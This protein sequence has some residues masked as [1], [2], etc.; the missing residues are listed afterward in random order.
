MD[1]EEEQRD[2]AEESSPKEKRKPRK[3]S[4]TPS[5]NDV[6]VLGDV[7]TFDLGDVDSS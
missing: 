6:E 4:R 7:E 1:E 2:A 3:K 5:M